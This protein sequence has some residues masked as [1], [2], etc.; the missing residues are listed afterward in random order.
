[1]I[2]IANHNLVDFVVGLL[3]INPKLFQGGS[4]YKYAP[5]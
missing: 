3:F 4:I 2:L 5:H 1:L